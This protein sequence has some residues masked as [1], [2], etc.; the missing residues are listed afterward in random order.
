LPVALLLLLA[1]LNAAASRLALLVSFIARS[2]SRYSYKWISHV[3]KQ[4]T[5]NPIVLFKRFFL[6]AAAFFN[7][8]IV[9]SRTNTSAAVCLTK[10]LTI[11]L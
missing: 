8:F 9:I 1:F 7:F 2:A 5:V 4:I 3:F 10:A 6:F 11:T